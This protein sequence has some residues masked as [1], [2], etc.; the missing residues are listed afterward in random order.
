MHTASVVFKRW[1]NMANPSVSRLSGVSQRDGQMQKKGSH[2]L[3]A[4][5][6]EAVSLTRSLIRAAQVLAP[7]TNVG[8]GSLP[9]D[10]SSTVSVGRVNLSSLLVTSLNPPGPLLP[11]RFAWHLLPRRSVTCLCRHY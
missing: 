5:P 4:Q 6:W 10:D 8:A 7:A 11:S 3:R 1:A 9:D 2:A